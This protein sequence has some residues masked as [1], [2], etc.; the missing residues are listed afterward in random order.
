[1]PK[2]LFFAVLLMLRFCGETSNDSSE[3][4]SVEGCLDPKNV[5]PEAVC[6]KIYAPVCGCDGKTYGNECEATAAGLTSW[7]EGECGRE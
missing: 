5:N 4:I 7:T 3:R 2:L 6:I 1:M